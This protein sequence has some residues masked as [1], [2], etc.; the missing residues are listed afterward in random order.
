[1]VLSSR[2]PAPARLRVR[3]SS[4]FL[5]LAVVALLA[6]FGQAGDTP[7]LHRQVAGVLP[8][9]LDQQGVTVRS[10]PGSES[11]P[12]TV[13]VTLSA[14]GREGDLRPLAAVAPA[15]HQGRIEYARDGLTEW[16]VVEGRGMQQGFDVPVRPEGS[17]RLLALSL[18]VSGD[19][20]PSVHERG[21]RVTLAAAGQPAVLSYKGLVAWDAIGRP[22]RAWMEPGDQ[23]GLV[24]LVDD[25]G[26]HYPVT[27]DPLITDEIIEVTAS[28][29][30]AKSTFGLSVALDA[31][32]GA[33][34]APNRAGSKKNE[35]SVYIIE[36][37]LGGTDNWGERTRIDA[38]D[39]DNGDRFGTAVAI[40]GDTLVVG[41]PFNNDLGNASGSVYVHERDQGGADAWG[42]VVK[43]LPA[44]GDKNDQFGYAVAV[45]GDV[46]A[47]SSP[48]DKQ[49]K[50]FIHGRDQGG[51]DAW[52]LVK[53]IQGSSAS[54]GDRFGWHLALDGDLLVV[55]APNDDDAAKNAGAVYVFEQDLGGA[56]NW[57]ER[58]KIVP[59]G[60]LKADQF[61]WRVDVFG[62]S[63]AVGAT[64]SNDGGKGAGK[65]F[66][67]ER[68]LGGSNAW[69]QF[70][71]LRNDPVSAKDQFGS[72][73]VVEGAA[74]IIGAANDG[75]FANNGG[76]MRVNSQD[77]GGTSNWGFVN[78]VG[79]SNASSGDRFSTSAD[80]DGTTLMVG[81][82]LVDG[83]GN[84]SGSVYIFHVDV[85][86]PPPPSTGRVVYIDDAQ[87]NIPVGGGGDTRRVDWVDL[88]ANGAPDLFELNYLGPDGNLA[89]FGDGLGAFTTSS[90]TSDPG[91]ALL[92]VVDAL[93]P[94]DGATDALP[95][96][97]V[98]FGDWDNDG[99]QDGYIGNGPTG[100]SPVR[101]HFLFNNSIEGSPGQFTLHDPGNGIDADLD[102]TYDARFSD[103][104]LDGFTDLIVVNRNEANRLYMNEGDDTLGQFRAIADAGSSPV[105]EISDMAPANPLADPGDLMG[106]RALEVGDLDGDGDDDV[107]VVNANSGAQPNQVFVNQGG[108]QG[109]QVGDML[110]LVGDDAVDIH[111][112]SYGLDLGDLDNDGDLDAFICNRNEVNFVLR[113]E[114]APGGD[115]S[116]SRILGT[117]VDTDQ[118][119]F[120]GTPVFGDSYDCDIAD[121]ENDGDADI[122]VVNRVQRNM[123]YLASTTAPTLLDAPAD[124]YERV[125]EGPVQI[126]RGNSRAVAVADI[127]IY[128]PFVRTEMPEIALGNSGAGLNRYYQNYGEHIEELDGRTTD[129][130]FD[131]L[132]WAEGTLTETTDVTLHV[133][134]A[135]PSAAGQLVLGITAANT[136]WNGGVL[137]P[138]E[139]VLT[140]FVTDSNG[141]ADIVILGSSLPPNPAGLPFWFQARV[142]DAG[143]VGPQGPTSLSNA[144]VIIAE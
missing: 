73:V 77:Q 110:G 137:V 54:N 24:I 80:M 30:S 89:H 72:S 94:L 118:A 40:S 125:T 13:T 42:E 66:L 135:E 76:S 55:G 36:R 99:D 128:G 124:A 101:N 64:R 5:S 105:S 132:L 131:P 115:P 25:R 12:W 29:A 51:P 69:G 126:D 88:D 53:V 71:Q 136:P 83:A 20:S 143:M 63:V 68:D 121:L 97:A 98:A 111:G 6:P 90:M 107:F 113:N 96:K 50:V 134:C 122:V 102:H 3:F 9:R 81:A 44:A 26:A 1:M 32:T 100:G 138:S 82:P 133:L 144:I 41:A 34:G 17:G 108:N 95:S 39:A 7:A 11:S 87:A 74:L 23:G 10:A 123:I 2:V 18:D 45:A 92:G 8:V 117:A 60:G 27:I 139:D 59:S 65:A 86:S 56:D 33:V 43:L 93:A 112:I 4:L 119:G 22:L 31:D 67:Y 109:G 84:D 104:N 48:K 37:D 130:D 75:S 28:D 116:F 85:L 46:L 47:A 15:M 49:G 58:A 140:G 52:G 103:I 79:A 57:G 35:G 120:L 114:S 16:W 78:E 70:K 19:L 38:S 129:G 127:D 62:S 61:G 106:S 141:E 142:A 91:N 14:M 21:Q